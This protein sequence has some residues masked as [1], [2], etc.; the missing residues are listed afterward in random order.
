MGA[1]TVS[2][3]QRIED[4]IALLS[5]PKTHWVRGFPDLSDE[6][7]L[8]WDRATDGRPV[9]ISHELYEFLTELVRDYYHG[10][11]DPE[12]YNDHFAT[13]RKDVLLF[14]DEALTAAEE[15]DL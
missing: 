7:C 12:E 5:D 9:R 11:I 3:R 4:R 1:S 14:L 15:L 10:S 6:C 2:L 13:S 8:A